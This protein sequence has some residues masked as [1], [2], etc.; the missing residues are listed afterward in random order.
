LNREAHSYYSFA[1]IGWQRDG[2]TYGRIAGF[3]R[4]AEIL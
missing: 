3:R 1:H 2:G 4:G